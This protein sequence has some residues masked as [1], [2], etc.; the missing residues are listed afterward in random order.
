M[1]N[2]PSEEMEVME[3]PSAHLGFP[4]ERQGLNPACVAPQFRPF[5]PAWPA[6]SKTWAVLTT[7]PAPL[8]AKPLLMLLLVSRQSGAEQRELSQ[9]L[10]F[11]HGQPFGSGSC[12]QTNERN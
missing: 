10:N 12:R 7:G 8:E 4:T 1:G 5:G 3:M 2:K 11:D 6:A 9:N